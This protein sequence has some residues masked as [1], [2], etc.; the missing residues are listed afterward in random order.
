MLKK[1]AQ[2][3][4]TREIQ[5]PQSGSSA[6]TSPSTSNNLSP[7]SQPHQVTRC[8]SVPSS[9]LLADLAEKDLPFL[10][11]NLFN[12]LHITSLDLRHNRLGDGLRDST[13]RVSDPEIPKV[14]KGLK[15]LNIFVRLTRLNLANNGLKA[16]PPE[17][18][19]LSTLIV[20]NITGNQLTELP[21]QIGHLE[22][23]VLFK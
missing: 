14:E 6:S 23:R 4:R 5:S 1:F 16:L 15:D 17:I 8:R 3:P 9:E 2:S 20:L 10:P 21:G 22:R 13:T 11:P 12:H 7:S 19:H 18:G